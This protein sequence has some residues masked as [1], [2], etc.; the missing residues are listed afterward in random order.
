VSPVELTDRRGKEEVG[1]EVN[2]TDDCE[3]D[4]LYI[5]YSI[6]SGFTFFI[7]EFES[8]SSDPDS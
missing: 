7:R 8:P 1:E 5:N 3:K 6:L 2:H 4:R